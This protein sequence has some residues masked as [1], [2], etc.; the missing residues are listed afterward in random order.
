MSELLALAK[1]LRALDQEALASLL[2][3]CSAQSVG[4]LLDLAK[5]LLSKRELERRIRLLPKAELSTLRS[6]QTSSV[7]QQSYLATDVPFV[8]AFEI[9]GELRPIEFT[10]KSN[11]EHGAVLSLYTTLMAITEII[12]SC[13]RR[14]LTPTKAG[15]RTGE[16][17][18]LAEVLKVE[19]SQ[20]QLRFNLAQRAG[21]V[22][23]HGGRYVASERGVEFIQLG[24]G[25]RFALLC[26]S[27]WDLPKGFVPS[28]NVPQQL[29]EHFPLLDLNQLAYLQFGDLLGL[30]ENFEATE[31]T[32]PG[33][34][35][36]V[37][38]LPQALDQLVIQSDLS[39]ISLGPISAS[40]HRSLDMFCVAEDLGLASR[41]R[42][43]AASI[44]HSLES[45]FLV[46]DILTVLTSHSKSA[47]PQPLEYLLNEVEK[48][49][50][51]L[52]ISAL[53]GGSL[54]EADDR[55]W[56]RQ[57][58]AQSSLRGLLLEPRPGAIYS[59]LDQEMIYFNLRAAGYLAVMVN[60]FGSVI[61][62]RKVA[63]VVETSGFDYGAK[64]QTLLAEEAA[65][66][67]GDDV[68]RQL[69]FAMKNKL[70]VGLRVNYPD[71]SEKEHL[72]EPLGLAGPRLRGRDSV[73]QAE[74]TLP[75]SRVSAIWLA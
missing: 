17:K 46:E 26:Q 18:E 36:L 22:I 74:I 70:R 30:T 2:S 73:K 40:L 47:I 54:I 37:D 23:Q 9:A 25:Q 6:N 4:D 69:N 33:D 29:K 53:A 61:S 45:G 56:L 8:Q 62:P 3:D 75:L 1:S 15:L 39:V 27:I 10:A 24:Q 60:E 49:F 42:I 50:G 5:L 16:L 20:L 43:S 38:K 66:P 32:D 51:T 67:E 41:F 57:I 44:S 12:F 21:L 58:L 34:L 31:I 64:A 68:I 35:A 14:F 72:I 48:K 28:G 65:A 63:E 13:E 11:E 52:R 7:L 55:I 19:P 59:R 71:G